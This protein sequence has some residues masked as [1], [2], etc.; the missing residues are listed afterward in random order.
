MARSSIQVT[1][2]LRRALERRKLHPRESY[3]EVIQRALAAGQ[4]QPLAGPTLPAP[5]RDAVDELRRRLAERYGAR[6]R[7]LI[8]YG[9]HA[10]GDATP[11]SDVDLLVVLAGPV[12]RGAEIES[13]VRI[14][15][16]LLLARG[17]HLSALPMDEREYLTRA[18]P[19][20]LNVRREGVPL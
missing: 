16:D 14:T 10:R 8:L 13:I 4:A 2:V 12:E 19:L 15:Y 20:L 11:T 7:R 5:V 3:E 6:L 17:V 9:S 18:T 1:S